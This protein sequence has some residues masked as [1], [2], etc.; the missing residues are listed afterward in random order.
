MNTTK[1]FIELMIAGLGLIVWLLFLTLS[2]IE[3]P[4][5]SIQLFFEKSSAGIL[6][7]AIVVLL[8]FIYAV[9]I[10]TDRLVDSIFDRFFGDK[11][12]AKKFK[13]IKSS[14][15]DKE[16]R[17]KERKKEIEEEL[18]RNLR[19]RK[20]RKKERKKELKKILEEERETNKIKYNKTMAKIFSESETLK[21]VF[22]YLRMKIRICRAWSFNSFFIL[23]FFNI[24]LLRHYYCNPQYPEIF[25]IF[26]LIWLGSIIFSSIAWTSLVKKEIE[27]V[28]IHNGI[29]QKKKEKDSQNNKTKKANEADV[30]T[31]QS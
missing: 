25:V 2:Y 21:D 7:S 4:Y 17:K 28:I 8:P 18:K 19:N 5:P 31:G 13:N 30:N 11:L 14:K 24:F 10:V 20:K 1:Y 22:D 23:L 27:L 16:E 9:G 12:I 15:T 29:I 26:S 6:A 3:V